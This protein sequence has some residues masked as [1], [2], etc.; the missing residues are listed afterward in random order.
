MSENLTFRLF[1]PDDILGILRLWEEESGWGGITEEQF[2]RWIYTPF[3]D[4]LISVAVDES[5]KIV[6]QQIFM[7]SKFYLKGA[8]FKACRVLAPIIAKNFRDNI[9]QKNHPFYQM[10][11]V[12]LEAA[13]LEKFSLIYTF[14]LHS[15]M[16]VMKIFPRFGLPK[17]EIAE[18]EC[19]SLPKAKFENFSLMSDD[20][21]TSQTTEIS[22]A[23]DEFWSVAK[24][25]FPIKCGMVRDAERLRWKLGN[26]LIFT[27]RNGTGKIIGYVGINQKTGLVIDMLTASPNDL[28]LVFASTLKALNRF[29]SKNG[30]FN[31][32]GIGLMKTE[33]FAP[34]IENFGFEKTDFKFAFGCYSIDSA[35]KTE[36]I[37]P[38]NWY[39]L[40]DD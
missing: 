1:Q 9:R 16:T 35:V 19:W 21:E 7:P 4:C 39:K 12:C 23:F 37:L 22:V 27:T 17:F 24:D 3:G 2:K 10:H 40:P 38:P 36:S 32:G 6:G 20:L 29:E 14:P 28:E 5:G 13:I 31:F 33:I 8:Q 15:W 26:H 25:S 11:R 30:A 34:L 18:Y